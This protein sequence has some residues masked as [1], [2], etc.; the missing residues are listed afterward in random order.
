MQYEKGTRQY[1]TIILL[2][3]LCALF[4]SFV[5]LAYLNH[6]SGDF[7]SYTFYFFT[8]PTLIL[9]EVCHSRVLL[10]QFSPHKHA[11]YRSH[12]EPAR[13]AAGI[14]QAMKPL[15]V[16]IKVRVHLYPIRV[17]FQ[18]WRIEQRFIRGKPWND[19]I[20]R[21]YEVYDIRH[22]TIRH[23]GGNIPGNSVWKRRPYI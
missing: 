21:F 12:H 20:Y 13:P 7:L 16:G 2:I 23:C 15:Y 8:G 17:E 5:L 6:L 19:F 11:H 9:I 3:S 18:L 1:L 10:N 4:N 22:R 14:T